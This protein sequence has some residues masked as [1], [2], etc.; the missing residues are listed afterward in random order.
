MRRRDS[1]TEYISG[2][3][4]FLKL[5]KLGAPEGNTVIPLV[6]LPIHESPKHSI[7]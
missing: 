1:G 4:P 2:V 5:V 6:K 3:N 7:V